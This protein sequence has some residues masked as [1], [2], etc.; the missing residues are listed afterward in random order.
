MFLFILLCSVLTLK[1]AAV[2]WES[3]GNEYGFSSDGDYYEYGGFAT[4][5]AP[6]F[7][8]FASCWTLLF[9]LYLFLTSSSGYTCTD[10]PIGRFFNWKI[11]FAVDSL[12]AVFWFAGFVTLAQFYQSGPCDTG[13]EGV[14][15]T[16]ITSVLVGVC[17][18]YDCRS[19]FSFS[20]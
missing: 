10:R 17:M 2:R 20:F 8:I 7:V 5:G 12:S 4:I 14:C 6:K 11:A 19:A 9:T 1:N 18:W 13:A 15:G 16:V 3:I